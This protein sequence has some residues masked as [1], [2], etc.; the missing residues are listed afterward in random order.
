MRDA[1][2]M[3]MRTIIG[4]GCYDGHF[5]GTRIDL[6]YGI[7]KGLDFLLTIRIAGRWWLGGHDGGGIG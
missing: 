4:L 2:T 3:M 6:D 5:T 1:V 7:E